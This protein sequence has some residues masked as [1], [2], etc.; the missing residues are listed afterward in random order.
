MTPIE[1]TKVEEQL[2]GRVLFNIRAFTSRGRMDLPIGVLGGASPALDEDKVL[3]SALE[4]SEELTA[5]IRL[6]LSL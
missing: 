3:R 6:R 2:N 1:L 5:A 4:L